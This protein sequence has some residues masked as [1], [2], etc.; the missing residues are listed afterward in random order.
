MNATDA[1]ADPAE[2]LL[3]GTRSLVLNILVGVGA[4]IALSGL[5]LRTLDRGATD[6]PRDAVELTAHGMLV[7]LVV[8]SFA[9]R[10]A[11]GSRSALRP[12]STRASRFRRAHALGA[13][14]GAL[15]APLGTAYAFAVRPTLEAVAPF[16]VAA[17]ALGFLSLPRRRELDGFDAPLPPRPVPSEPGP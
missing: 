12:P 15:A 16:W 14:L 5:G 11:V 6:W 2:A 8:A 4:V 9:A 3:D 17:L 1:S 10:R 7:G 13:A